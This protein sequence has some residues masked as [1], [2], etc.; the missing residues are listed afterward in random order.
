MK[1]FN[2]KFNHGKLYYLGLILTAICLPLSKFALSVSMIVLIS[3]WLL[4]LDFK[5]KWEE[6]KA[7]KSILIFT[8]IFIVH[9]IWLIHTSNFKYAFHDLGNKAILILYPIIIG[10]SKKLSIRELK[11]ILIWF[12]I[13]VVVS[14]IISTL[15]LVGIIEY[16]I[17]S[18]RNISL[19][20]SHI[21]L[22]LLVNISIFSL[23][24]ILFSGRFENK[25]LEI[26]IY[27]IFIVWLIIFLF[28]LKS[29]TGLGVFIITFFLVLGFVSFK[30]KNLIPRLFLQLGLITIFLLIASF[31]THS[32]SKFYTKEYI[33]FERLDKYTESGNEYEVP[34]VNEVLENGN[35]VWVYVCPKELKQEWS[36]LSSIPYEG[37]DKKEQEI[38]YTILRYLASK[39]YRKDSAGLSKLSQND[40]KNIENGIANYIFEDKYA[41]YPKIY[42]VL[43]Q[44]DR[45]RKG[46]PVLGSSVTLRL[47]FFKT[48]IDIIDNNFWFGVGTGDVQDAFDMQYE[49]NK[50]QLPDQNRLRAHNQYITFFLTFGFVGFILLFFSM[51]Y[52]VFKLKGYKNY[53]F[54]VVLVIALLSFINED[55]LETQIGITFFTFFY[56]L[57]LFGS[58]IGFESEKDCKQK[59]K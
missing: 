6:I 32:I 58:K 10:T 42:E 35:H 5:R 27:A 12:S 40:I 14:T 48:A 51:L 57:F 56:S 38:Q 44:I 3:N 39:G 16:S 29:F 7:N 50:S 18:I 31:L 33:D 4:E 54:V 1:I 19:F 34:K 21:R 43:W 37:L 28:L 22:S 13:S 25:N 41:L 15:I 55:T 47:V 20:M 26:I 30:I 45:Y 52:P 53:L 9:L 24:Y 46:Y 23:G 36:K 59:I 11:R 49:L 8:G 2:I 17:Q